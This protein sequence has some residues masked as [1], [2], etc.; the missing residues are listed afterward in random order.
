MSN[1][2]KWEWLFRGSQFW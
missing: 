2:E 1:L